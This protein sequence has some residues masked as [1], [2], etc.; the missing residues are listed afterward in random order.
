MVEPGAEDVAQIE[1]VE[2]GSTA[3]EAEERREPVGGG[4]QQRLR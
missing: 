3:S 1:G 4:R 2:I